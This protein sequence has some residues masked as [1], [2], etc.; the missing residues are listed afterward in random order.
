M[1][2]KEFEIAFYEAMYKWAA[3]GKVDPD[4]RGEWEYSYPST[5]WR[6]YP[7]PEMPDYDV[8]VTYRWKPA[9]KRMTR[10]HFAAGTSVELVAPEVDAPA[11]GTPCYTEC[12]SG[13]S[14]CWIWDDDTFDREALKNAKVFLTS[15]DAQ[16]MA[17]AQRKQRLGTPKEPEPELDEEKLTSDLCQAWKPL[18]V[19]H[20]E[21]RDWPGTYKFAKIAI[22]LFKQRMGGA[23]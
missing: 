21:W 18:T 3:G 23:S 14:D 5:G 16:A 2:A 1:N 8:A 10:L 4:P 13:S 22:H 9:K 19:N 12:S 6:S 11:I 17:D 15:E 20:N 7:E